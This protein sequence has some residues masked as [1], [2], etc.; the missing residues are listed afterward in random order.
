MH[1]SYSFLY[2]GQCVCI[3]IINFNDFVCGNI[4]FAEA[5]IACTLIFLNLNN[6]YVSSVM[7]IMELADTIIFNGKSFRICLIHIA[8]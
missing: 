2:H 6:F 8:L 3:C 4:C 1:F 7:Y 5:E